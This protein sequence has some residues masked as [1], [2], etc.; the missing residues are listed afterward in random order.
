[1]LGGR[2]AGR[3]RAGAEWVRRFA[4]AKPDGAAPPRIALIGAD[5]RAVMV[6]G[7]SGLL[8]VHPPDARSLYEPSKRQVMWPSGAVAQ[9]FSAEEPQS[10][11]RPQF[12]AAWCDESRGPHRCALA[13]RA[14]RNCAHAR[15]AGVR[16]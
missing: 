12:S 16:D 1:M 2:G 8:A 7:V 10:L 9:L 14:D 4:C 15:V 5:A 6:E 3:T 13:A 11:R